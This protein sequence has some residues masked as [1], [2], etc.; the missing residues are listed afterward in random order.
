MARKQKPVQNIP[1]A[2]IE[3]VEDIPEDEQMRLVEQSGVL[4]L[5]HKDESARKAGKQEEASLANEIFDTII[6]LIPFSCLYIGMD[7][8]IKQQYAQHPGLK[9]EFGQLVNAFP[10][11]ALFIFYTNRYKNTIILQG[12]MTLASI[13]AGSH[14]IYLINKAPWGTVI[15]QC[16]PLGVIWVYT[17]VQLQLTYACVALLAVFGYV[18]YNA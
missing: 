15:R 18:R 10:I 9:E 12:A 3:E 4:R 13:A 14:M 8:M 6:L 16:P 2:Y 11:M 17:V 5:P 7:I 1:Q